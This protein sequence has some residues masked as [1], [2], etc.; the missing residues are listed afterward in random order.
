MSA[1]VFECDCC[2]KLIS[3][4]RMVELPDDREVCEHCAADIERGERE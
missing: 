4:G 2:H 3:I 1:D